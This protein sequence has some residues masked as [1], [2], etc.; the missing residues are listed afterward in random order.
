MS[1]IIQDTDIKHDGGSHNVEIEIDGDRAVIRFGSSFTLRMDET[2]L[3]K[4]R[5]ILYDTTRELMLARFH[6]EH[7]ESIRLAKISLG[8]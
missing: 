8:V 7:A 1:Y 6:A 3:D 4:L 5:G 2:N